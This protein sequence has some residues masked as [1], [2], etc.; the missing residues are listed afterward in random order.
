MLHDGKGGFVIMPGSPFSTGDGPGRIAIGDVDG[1][2]SPDIVAANY[3]SR[4]VTVLRGYKGTFM[5]TA[6]IPVGNHPQGIALGDLNG[7]GK[8]DIVVANSDDNTI[9]ILLGRHAG[10]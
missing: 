7:D 3:L 9:S 6:T 10:P 1:D 4:S 5:P 2:G 8:A